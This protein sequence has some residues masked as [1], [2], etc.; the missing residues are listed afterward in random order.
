MLTNLWC[1]HPRGLLAWCRKFDEWLGLDSKDLQTNLPRA[2]KKVNAIE[3]RQ[4]G[5]LYPQPIYR[6]LSHWLTFI[7]ISFM[8]MVQTCFSQFQTS[9]PW[10]THNF[11]IS[12]FNTLV[13][14]TQI[15][16][17][18]EN[19]STYSYSSI[20]VVLFLLI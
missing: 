15:H 18:I 20:F 6:Y 9:K 3:D 14:P 16:Q 8:K 11:F 13:A 10:E 4:T 17:V 19:S 7:L 2:I 1:C 12:N 5:C